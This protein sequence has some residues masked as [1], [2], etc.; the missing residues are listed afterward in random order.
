M[1]PFDSGVGLVGG[2]FFIFWLLTMGA[3]VVGYLVLLVAVW[4]GMKAHEAIAQ[5]MKELVLHLKSQPRPAESE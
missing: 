4:R 1:Q 3:I 2:F 5:T